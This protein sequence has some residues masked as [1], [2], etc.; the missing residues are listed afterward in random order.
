MNNNI[1][2]TIKFVITLRLLISLLFGDE[3]SINAC[4]QKKS[5]QKLIGYLSGAELIQTYDYMI[6]AARW[7]QSF[8]KIKSEQ[9]KYGIL[10]SLFPIFPHLLSCLLI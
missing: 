9:N 1:F 10:T 3:M 5:W 7:K 4:T 6:L 2:K 8:W